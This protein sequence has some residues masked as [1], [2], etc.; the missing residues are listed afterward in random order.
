[1]K[2]ITTIAIVFFLLSFASAMYAGETKYYDFTDKVDI[3]K[4]ITWEVVDNS[5]GL[6]I[7]TNS[8]G[9][10]L[11]IAQDFKPDNFTIT[12][13]ITGENKEVVVSVDTSRQGG[14]GSSYTKK[15]VVVVNETEKVNETIEEVEEKIDEIIE[16][17]IIEEEGS[18]I[19]KYVLIIAII[20]LL[21]WA[22]FY[23]RVI[24]KKKQDYQQVFFPIDINDIKEKED[25]P[26]I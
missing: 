15:K 22:I 7:T 20:L 18:N 9:A 4:N 25:E 6:N 13:T 16:E 24:M 14:G 3:I 21:I 19:W 2:T 12:F 10:I 5:S 8:T 23:L 26:N 17:E 11:S 1:M